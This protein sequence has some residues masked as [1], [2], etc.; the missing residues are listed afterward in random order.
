MTRKKK[1]QAQ[2]KRRK[3]LRVCEKLI[4]TPD[5]WYPAILIDGAPFVQGKVFIDDDPLD[6]KH[7]FF[8]RICFWGNDD[9]GMEWDLYTNDLGAAEREYDRWFKW[10]ASQSI[11][12]VDSL[13]LLGFVHA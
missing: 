12:S 1:L 11:I 13:K 6:T 3:R 5:D 9:F 7:R 8:F 4:P 2:E 10:L